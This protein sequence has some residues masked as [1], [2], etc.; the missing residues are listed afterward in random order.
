MITL[1]GDAKPAIL[2]KSYVTRDCLYTLTSGA[3]LSNRFYD[4][5]FTGQWTSVGSSEG[6]TET[7]T[8]QF[9]EGSLAVERTI[10]FLALMN[11][12][13]K[14]FTIAWSSGGAYTTFT[15]ADYTS[16]VANNAAKNFVLSLAT[17]ITATHIRITATNTIGAVAQKLIGGI[18]A[19]SGTLQFS[20]GMTSY[21]PE[22]VEKRTEVKMSDGST[23]FGYIYRSDNSFEFYRAK[24]SWRF[25]TEAERTILRTVKTTTA[26]FLWYPEPYEQPR[27]LFLCVFKSVKE[28]YSTTYKAAGYDIDAEIMEVGGA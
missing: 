3:T 15:G 25:V 13:L 10:D 7:I 11:I 12:N 4:M 22:R 5:D 18:V 28:K 20:A 27:D 23:A 24:A 17:P 21:E 14:N 6:A 26:P 2:S 1:T 9:Y 16:G 19:A 8:I